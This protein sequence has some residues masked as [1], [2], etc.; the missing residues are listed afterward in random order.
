M[1]K[2]TTVEVRH[3]IWDDELGCRVE[4]GDDSDGLDMIEIVAVEA[5]GTRC[6][7]VYIREQDAEHIA[8]ALVKVAEHIRTRVK[9]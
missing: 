2:G 3:R 5:D 6:Q 4:V 7:F 9:K 1:G 8:N